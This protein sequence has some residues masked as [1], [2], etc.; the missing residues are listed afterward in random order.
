MAGQLPLSGG[1][2]DVLD[3]VEPAGDVHGGEVYYNAAVTPW[4]HL[5]VD[6]QA[7]QPTFRSSDTA[8]VLGLRGKLDF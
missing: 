8:V 3:A 6:L 4:F 2:R 5:T 1:F 7:I